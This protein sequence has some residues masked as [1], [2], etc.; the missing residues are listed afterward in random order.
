[1]ASTSRYSAR[2][3]CDERSTN[4]YFVPAPHPAWATLVHPDLPADEAYEQ[5]WRELEHVLRLDEPDPLAAW[6]ERM[7]VLNDYAAQLAAH[8][9]DAIELRGPG[10]ELTI[11]PLRPRPGRLSSSRPRRACGIS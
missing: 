8:R 1:M 4:W 6:D 2:T 5:L 11:G 10:T 7:A 3:C 9:F